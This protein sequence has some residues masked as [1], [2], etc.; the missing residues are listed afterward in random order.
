MSRIGRKPIIIPKDINLEINNNFI[1]IQGP[2]GQLSRQ[3]N[4]KIKIEVNNNELIV[5]RLNDDKIQ[6]SMHGL[7]RT[8]IANMIEGVTKG[9]SKTL[10]IVGIGYRAA[11]TENNLTLTLGFSHPIVEVPPK[12]ISIDVPTQNKIVING[13][14]KEAVG[15]FAAKI[16]GYRAPE[17]YKGK[18]IKYEGELIRRKAGK[19]GAKGKK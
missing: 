2:K 18:G 11:K 12:G 3:I 1:T 4:I 7:S 5:R 10:E 17:P 15:A 16:R 19:T 6:K 14:D 13:I 8:L 9:F